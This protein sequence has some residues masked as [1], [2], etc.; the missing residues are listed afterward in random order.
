MGQPRPLFR[1]FSVFSNK[2]Y[3]FKTIK[4]EN[5]HPVY[6]TRIR[7]HDLSN[8]SRLDNNH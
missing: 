1:L 2:Q 5:V 7:T 8:M 6:S 3:I 4:C